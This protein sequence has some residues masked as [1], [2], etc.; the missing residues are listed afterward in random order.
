[1]LFFSRN[2]VIYQLMVHID[3]LMHS[4]FSS[5]HFSSLLPIPSPMVLGHLI[6]NFLLFVSSS[7]HF[8][9]FFDHLQLNQVYVQLVP[10]R[11]CLAQFILIG[12]GTLLFPF[13]HSFSSGSRSFSPHLPYFCLCTLTL[14][15][16]S[17]INFN[18]IMFGHTWFH[19]KGTM[20]GS[21]W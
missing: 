15:T 10:R 9:R 2:Q 13:A 1:M 7:L 3:R 5:T 20:H 11:R 12:L 4:S 8:H 21:Y 17:S 16:H 14:P 19:G 18:Q 6:P